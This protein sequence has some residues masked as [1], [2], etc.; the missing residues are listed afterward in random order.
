[1]SSASAVC[2]CIFMFVWGGMLSIMCCKQQIMVIECLLGVYTDTI[3]IIDSCSNIKTLLTSQYKFRNCTSGMKGCVVNML[4]CDFL[5]FPN[6]SLW[7]KLY[8][9]DENANCRIRCRPVWEQRLWF[10]VKKV[11]FDQRTK[12]PSANNARQKQST[13]VIEFGSC[14]RL[15]CTRQSGTAP[16]ET[17]ASPVF[18]QSFA[19]D[20]A[21]ETAAPPPAPPLWPPDYD[22]NFV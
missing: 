5:F 20:V 16:A 11:K 2:L 3:T 8:Y 9:L 1:M 10:E 19:E 4:N 6:F 18:I 22:F 13:T 21:Q 7:M 17:P 14:K 12:Q 15:L